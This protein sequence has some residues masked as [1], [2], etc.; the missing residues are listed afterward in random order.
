MSDED[1]VPRSVRDFR[2][3]ARTGFWVVVGICTVIGALVAHVLHEERQDNRIDAIKAWQTKK[4]EETAKQAER[5]REDRAA[6][7]R[8]ERWRRF[9]QEVP[10]PFPGIDS[11]RPPAKG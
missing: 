7:A 11:Q 5:D 1:D 8:R 6:E 10:P 2:L 3:M 4:D 9:R